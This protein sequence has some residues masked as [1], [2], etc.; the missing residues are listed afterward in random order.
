MDVIRK[1]PLLHL[2]ILVANALADLMLLMINALHVSQN[3]LDSL[4]V[5]VNC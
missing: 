2:V 4:I 3:T 5:Q 1:D